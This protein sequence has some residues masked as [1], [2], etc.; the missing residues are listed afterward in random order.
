M[1]AAS[2]DAVTMGTDG[3]DLWKAAERTEGGGR[4]GGGVG[5]EKGGGGDHGR[6]ARGR[7]TGGEVGFKGV[8]E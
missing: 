8:G 2:T 6:N 7:K 5:E 1:L 4:R 3:V